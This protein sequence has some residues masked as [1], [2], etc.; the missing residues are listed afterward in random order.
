MPETCTFSALI[1]ESIL[2]SQRRDRI[3]DL[4]SYARSTIRECQVLA[5]FEQDLVEDVLTADAAPYIWA[6]PVR[7]RTMLAARPDIV[8]RRGKRKWFANKP[9]GNKI[10][11]TDFFLYLSGSSFIFT[12]D[13][14]ESGM[15]I[16]V[17]YFTYA[18]KFV[19]Y[20]EADRPAVYDPET[21]TWTYHASYDIDD[22]TRTT[23][24]E[25][26]SNWLVE[27]W[28]DLILEGMLSKVFKSVGDDRSKSSFALY[29][30]MQKD[31]LASERVIYLKEH[32]NNG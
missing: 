15:T 28:Y 24:R 10:A 25:L 16:D 11:D 9:P 14:F 1:D 29:K 26:V 5:F 21:E 4:V 17:A 2:R 8:G 20:A 6:R 32:D 7:L 22:A 13:E 3:N 12:G 23:A 30:Q 27:H 18:R 19:Y 31:L